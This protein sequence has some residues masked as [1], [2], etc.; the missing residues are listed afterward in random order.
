MAKA[1]LVMCKH[2][3]EVTLKDGSTGKQI[4]EGENFVCRIQSYGG[5]VSYKLWEQCGPAS[6]SAE[7]GRNMP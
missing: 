4:R 6:I 1:K 5:A 7:R 2:D 3:I